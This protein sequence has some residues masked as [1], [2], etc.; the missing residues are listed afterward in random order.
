MNRFRNNWTFVIVLLT[1][2]CSWTSW[3]NVR[4]VVRLLKRQRPNFSSMNAILSKFQISR[5][6]VQYFVVLVQRRLRWT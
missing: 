5:G 2:F 1:Y 3:M 6:T 4:L